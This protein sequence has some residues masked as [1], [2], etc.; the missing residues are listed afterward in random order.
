MGAPDD[1]QAWRQASAAFSSV[2]LGGWQ[3]GRVQFIAA[4]CMARRNVVATRA[5]GSAG[6]CAQSARVV[7]PKR[8][9]STNGIDDRYGMNSGLSRLVIY[10]Q[11]CALATKGQRDG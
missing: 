6:C 7:P 3:P 4:A 2:A 10:T 9:T 5:T 8:N 1:G 11:I